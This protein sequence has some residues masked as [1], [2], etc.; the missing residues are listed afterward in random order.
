VL[1]RLIDQVFEHRAHRLEP[2]ISRQGAKNAKEIQ[3]IIKSTRL[4]RSRFITI[5]DRL[6]A[7]PAFHFISAFLGGLGVLAANFRF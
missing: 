4:H 6:L 2:Q 5:P 1:I 7:F 3:S